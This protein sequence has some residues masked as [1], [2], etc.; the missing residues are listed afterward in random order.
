MNHSISRICSSRESVEGVNSVSTQRRA[1]STWAWASDGSD[2]AA[3]MKAAEP[4]EKSRRLMAMVLPPSWAPGEAPVAFSRSASNP[5]EPRRRVSE[6]PE[7]SPPHRLADQAEP[8]EVNEGAAEQAQEDAIAA[9][10]GDAE[11]ADALRL[12]AIEPDHGHDR[13]QQED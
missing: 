7:R 2:A 13:E 1:A 12:R 4:S 9:G 8:G 5:A 10:C 11:R 6:R 3:M